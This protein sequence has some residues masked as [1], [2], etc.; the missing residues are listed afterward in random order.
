MA[1]GIQV[2]A[3][4][5]C[6]EPFFSEYIEGSSNNKAIEIYNPG[7]VVIDLSNYE[8]RLFANGAITPSKFPFDD[9]FLYL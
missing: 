7:N 1:L 6:P 2:N 8:L 5:T 3:Q 9:Y 4:E